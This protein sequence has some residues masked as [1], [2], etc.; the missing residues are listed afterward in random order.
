MR[1]VKAGI[2]MA[3]QQHVAD[4]LLIYLCDCVLLI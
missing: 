1:L 4:N 2:A 3:Q